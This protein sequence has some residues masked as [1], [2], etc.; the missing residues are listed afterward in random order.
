M[1][2]HNTYK[3]LPIHFLILL[4]ILFFVSCTQADLSQESGKEVNLTVSVS[5]RASSD[6]NAIGN[7]TTISEVF[8]LIYNANYILENSNELAVS[9]SDLNAKSWV[10]KEGIKHVYVI[11]NPDEELKTRLNAEPSHNDLLTMI[12]APSAFDAAV[13]NISTNGILMTGK[14]EN[15]PIDQTA[16]SVSVS[17]APR[18]A[19]VD[20]YMRKEVNVTGIVTV[21]SV[22]VENTREA[23]RLFDEANS[24]THADSYS[25]SGSLIT[26]S[27]TEVTATTS[28][29]T[30]D[31]DY[32]II[33]HNYTFANILGTTFGETDVNK[34]I[35]TL[36]YT[37][38]SNVMTYTY[39]V[40]LSDNSGYTNSLSAIPDNV[41][42]V[43]GTLYKEGLSL[44]IN[45]T[46]TVTNDFTINQ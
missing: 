42:Q 24:Y 27:G 9:G 1:R 32:T 31:T 8:V 29:P 40:Y 12:T 3:T 44:S 21:K 15:Q 30:T 38:G 14:A 20:F 5:T 43:K 28:S 6:E 25:V 10:V 46:T 33:S 39:T 19:R 45:G 26:T 18:M 7:E 2:T 35:V 22:T 34:L 36:T 41:Y 23:G 13:G 4:V 11:A 16:T 17:I 37:E